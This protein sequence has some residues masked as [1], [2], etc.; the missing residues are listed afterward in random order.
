M[1]SPGVETL[2]YQASGMCKP[3]I[4]DDVITLFQNVHRRSNPRAGCP[5]LFSDGNMPTECLDIS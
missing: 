1:M 2:L 4:N 3:A 5:D